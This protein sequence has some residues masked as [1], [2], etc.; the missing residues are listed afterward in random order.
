LAAKEGIH[1]HHPGRVATALLF[2]SGAIMPAQQS[3]DPY[4]FAVGNYWIYQGRVANLSPP[5]SHEMTW[6]SQIAKVVHR[7][8]A[9][10]AAGRLEPSIV[11]A[12]FDNFPLGLPAWYPGSE[13]PLGILIEVNSRKF[14]AIAYTQAAVG[15]LG[16]QSAASEISAILLRVEDPR[17]N[18]SDL[19]D[20]LTPVIEMPLAPGKGWGLPFSHWSVTQSEKYSLTGVRGVC[21]PLNREGFIL[22]NSDNTGTVRFGF[23]PGVGITHVFSESLLPRGNP[24]HRELDVRLVEVH[25]DKP[26]AA[27]AR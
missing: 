21:D 3:T 12:V 5:D 2:A 13:G 15:K 7:N 22:E 14:Y 20:D 1:M 27:V 23:V 8:G 25:L 6:R 10:N 18:L 19:L 24:G 17:D 26:K 4:P 16:M 11:A 9:V